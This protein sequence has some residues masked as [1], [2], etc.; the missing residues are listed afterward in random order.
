MEGR[1]IGRWANLMQKSVGRRPPQRRPTGERCESQTYG[2]F[3]NSL[4][5]IKSRVGLTSSQ[6]YRPGDPSGR[7]DRVA[8]VE[9]KR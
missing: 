8:A 9:L 4:V 1:N 3:I 6:G 5:V 2:L 7:G